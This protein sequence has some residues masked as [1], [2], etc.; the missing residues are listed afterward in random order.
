MPP[1]HKTKI[2]FTYY[3]LQSPNGPHLQL[4]AYGTAYAT[5]LTR[6]FSSSE[7]PTGTANKNRSS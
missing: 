1:L 5:P 3:L 2:I 7:G 4:G 6:C